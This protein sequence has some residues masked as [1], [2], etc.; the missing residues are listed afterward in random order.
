METLY[1]DM[2]EPQFQPPVLLQRM[3]QAGW[4]GVKSGQVRTST[5]TQGF[6]N[7]RAKA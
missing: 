3:V 6:Y 5:H 7:Y 1:E 4:L 2:G